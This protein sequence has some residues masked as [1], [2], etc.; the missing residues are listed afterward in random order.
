MMTTRTV[1]RAGPGPTTTA[2]AAKA[3]RTTPSAARPRTRRTPPD[4]PVVHAIAAAERAVRR[5]TMHIA[6][7]V[8]GRLGLPPPEEIAFLG[9]VTVLVIAGVVEWPVGVLLGVGHA[10]ALNRRN[11]LVRAFGQA[12]EEA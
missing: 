2:K 10:L 3:T 4:R 11:R 12:L 5:D 7:P 6:L 9:G 1:T 8:I